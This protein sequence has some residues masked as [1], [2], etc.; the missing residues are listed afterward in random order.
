M[1]APP[2]APAEATALPER[3]VLS[4]LGEGVREFLQG[5]VT[6][7]LDRLG[8]ETPI[9][10][11]L[12]TPQG[13][14]L[15]DMLIQETEGGVL[16]D[17]AGPLGPDFK[18][19]LTLYRLRAKI[20]ITEESETLGIYALP[21][22]APLGAPD[23]RL[24]ELGRRAL[25][26]KAEAREHLAF[27]G[28]T[29]AAGEK[30]YAARRM[31]LGVAECGTD[32]APERLFALEANLAE[33]GAV[34]FKKGCFVGQEVTAR[35]HHR[36]ALRK[37]LWPLEL[38]ADGAVEPG[39]ALEAGGREI[40]TIEGVRGRRGFAL[41]RLDRLAE[42]GGSKAALTANGTTVRLGAPPWLNL[43]MALQDSE[44]AGA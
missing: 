37:R 28:L 13:K 10:A 11:A 18:R 36:T 21:P 32:F 5:I 41:L 15:A 42:A 40:G 23:P 25:L 31:A 24:P 16:I 22:D 6:G 43:E 33:L 38:D 29:L 9:A 8:P 1:A 7:N 17:C 27:A 20:K 34:D 44:K 2:P 35:M 4:L 3:T 12:L 30:A 19:R 26:P 39:A 14:V